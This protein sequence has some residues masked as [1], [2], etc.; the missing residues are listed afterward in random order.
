MA[1][2]GDRSEAEQERPPQ[3]ETMDEASDEP[4]K[5]LGASKI[6]AEQDKDKSL[7]V[8]KQTETPHQQKEQ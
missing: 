5:S 4:E 7:E 3:D 1:G 2:S 6:S 8:P